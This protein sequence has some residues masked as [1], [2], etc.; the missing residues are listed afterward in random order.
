VKKD[1]NDKIIY[2]LNVADVQEVAKEYLERKLTKR[3]VGIVEKTVPGFIDWIQAI[4][5]SIIFY[6]K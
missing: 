5:N 4:E 6:I 1:K 2:S 3:E